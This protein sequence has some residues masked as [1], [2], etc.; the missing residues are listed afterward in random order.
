MQCSLIKT[1]CL[2][3]QP[4]PHYQPRPLGEPHPTDELAAAV[5]P[6]V[7]LPIER[8]KELIYNE[9]RDVLCSE[10]TPDRLIVVSELPINAH[11]MILY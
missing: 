6:S 4:H 3:V 11:G 10:E 9:M 7:R 2:F 8:V 1:C 5:V